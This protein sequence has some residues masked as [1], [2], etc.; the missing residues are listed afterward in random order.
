MAVN[1]SDVHELHEFVVQYLSGCGGTFHS[2]PYG[3]DGR[4]VT[5]M[6]DEEYADYQNYLIRKRNQQEI[7]RRK[8][9]GFK[10]VK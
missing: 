3:K 1:P 8:E 7:Q 4:Y 9:S 10:C 2:G 6:T 5:L